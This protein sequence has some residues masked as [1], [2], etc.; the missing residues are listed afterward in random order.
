MDIAPRHLLFFIC[1]V[2]IDHVKDLGTSLFPEVGACAARGGGGRVHQALKGRERLCTAPWA[3][4]DMQAL[5][6]P[7]LLVL[8]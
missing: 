4:P 7:V 8:F 6:I 2:F 1:P 5:C 3:E